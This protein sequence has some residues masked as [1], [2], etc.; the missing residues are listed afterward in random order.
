MIAKTNSLLE[1]FPPMTT[2]LKALVVAAGLFAGVNSIS[3]ASAMSA[4]DI[5]AC[6]SGSFSSHGI[7]DCR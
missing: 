3:I 2:F 5:A 1:E 7:W 4:G 6:Q